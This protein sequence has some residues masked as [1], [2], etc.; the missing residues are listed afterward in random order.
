MSCKS[1][2]EKICFFFFCS[3][4]TLQ[5]RGVSAC[6][7]NGCATK[8]E[9]F[10]G[11]AGCTRYRLLLGTAFVGGSLATGQ[12]LQFLSP[13]TISSFRFRSQRIVFLQACHFYIPL[14]SV[15]ARVQHAHGNFPLYHV[16][17]LLYCFTASVVFR[18]QLLCQVSHRLHYE[19][20]RRVFNLQH[21]YG[22]KVI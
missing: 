12:N 17:I 9:Y 16:V 11:V 20:S 14:P 10:S 18:E 5:R 4:Q 2:A 1:W 6:V 13:P 8:R 7:H 21:T 3:S 15:H 19:N 22:C